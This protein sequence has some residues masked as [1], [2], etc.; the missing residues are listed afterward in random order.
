MIMIN[1]L[2]DPK[3]ATVIVEKIMQEFDLPFLIN[4]QAFLVTASAGVAVYP[5]DGE[6]SVSLIKNADTAMYKAKEKGNNQYALCTPEIKAELKT[7]MELSNDLY[8]ALENNELLLYYQP[9]INLATKEISG[10]EA[11]VRWQHP[12][13][14]LISPGVF[15]P[16]A[17]KNGLI[18]QIGDWVLYTASMQ[19]KKWQDMGLPKIQMA[20]NLSAVQIINPNIAKNIENTIKKS[21]LDPRYIELEITESIAIKETN[22]V[23]SVLNKLKK[24]GVSIAIDDFG[25]E[26]SSLSRLRDL[27]IDRIKIDMQFI[28]GIESNKKDKAI[29]MVIINLAKNLDLN[30]LA[31]GVE[32]LSQL[33]YL[34]EKLCDYVQGFYYYKPMP[35]NEIE[36]ILKIKKKV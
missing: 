3:M 12:T 30:V 20:V 7:N 9:Q 2:D 31:E 4:D 33:E 16:I 21:G 36:T 32:T 26:Y 10:L 6:D 35:A 15:I 23:L 19:N 29:T 24:I 14:G 25:T 28:Q 34:N 22:L 17:E 27:P 5:A 11:L 18:N 13:K 8:R 1:N